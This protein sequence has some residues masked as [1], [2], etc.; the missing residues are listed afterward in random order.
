VSVQKLDV[1][2]RYKSLLGAEDAFQPT[3]LSRLPNYTV[4]VQ[5]QT[6]NSFYR[7]QCHMLSLFNG[8]YLPICKGMHFLNSES[9]NY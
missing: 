1:V 6:Y 9:V 8:P 7:Q 4:H 5:Q 2:V 3:R